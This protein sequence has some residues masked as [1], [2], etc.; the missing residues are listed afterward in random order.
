MLKYNAGSTGARTVSAM[1][2]LYSLGL[3]PAVFA[4][5]GASEQVGTSYGEAGV[6]LMEAAEQLLHDWQPQVPPPP[7]FTLT[8]H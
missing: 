2:N 4:T 7:Y 5:G 3:F 8:V 1:R 6:R